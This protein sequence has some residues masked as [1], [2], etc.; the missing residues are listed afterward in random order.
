V[1]LKGKRLTPADAKDGCVQGSPSFVIVMYGDLRNFS[2]WSQKTPPD[3]VAQVIQEQY[4]RVLQIV[5]DH[6][7]V[8]F[9]FLGDGFLLVW[10]TD[11]EMTED[12][13]LR[14]AI[15]AA[16]HLH[17]KFH[18]TKAG[19][20]VLLPPGYGVGIAMGWATKVQPHTIIRELNEIDFVGYPLNCGARMQSLARP[21]GVTLSASVVDLVTKGGGDAFL[22]PDEPAFART[23]ALPTEEQL[24]KAAT[25]GGLHPLDR[26]EFRN[27]IWPAH[28][29]RWLE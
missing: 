26:T 9:K 18:H 19:S 10:E 28:S 16:F 3:I 8:F 21:Y 25:L 11:K 6:H 27:L 2:D 13:C 20:T 22:H 4:E 23:L 7:P 5:N 14:H 17:N 1:Y 15:D 24:A 29:P 12:V